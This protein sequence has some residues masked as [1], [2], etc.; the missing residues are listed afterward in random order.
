M[1]WSV[2]FVVGKYLLNVYTA[3]KIAWDDQQVY[4]TLGQ[5]PFSIQQPGLVVMA[6]NNSTT[7]NTWC[8]MDHPISNTYN[9]WKF[10]S[11]HLL[12]H[13]LEEE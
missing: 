6:P 5:L 10:T 12:T 13:L 7:P 11:N 4:Q 2:K 9:I 8:I 3:G 1:P